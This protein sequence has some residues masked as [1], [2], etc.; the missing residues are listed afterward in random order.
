MLKHTKSTQV[1]RRQRYD[2][3]PGGVGE[4]V[5]LELTAALVNAITVNVIKTYK[6]FKRT[7]WSKSLNIIGHRFLLNKEGRN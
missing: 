1:T 6:S 7:T 2:W 4:N 3:D 5:S